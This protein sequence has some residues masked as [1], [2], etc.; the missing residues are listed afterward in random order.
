MTISTQKSMTSNKLMYCCN[1]TYTIERLQR[2]IT[3]FRNQ[4]GGLFYLSEDKARGT[5]KVE[6]PKCICGKTIRL[7]EISE[8]LDE[9]FEVINA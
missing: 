4:V 9:N 8:I 3:F 6:H 7:L 2:E 5:I 1:Q